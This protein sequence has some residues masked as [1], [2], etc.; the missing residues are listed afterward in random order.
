MVTGKDTEV[1]NPLSL[2]IT[3][4]A[5]AIKEQKD[6]EKERFGNIDAGLKRIANRLVINEGYQAHGN[7]E[8][9]ALKEMDSSEAVEIL[10]NRIIGKLRN[11]V[12]LIS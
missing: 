8:L 7:P 12:D 9:E 1:L 3:K 5:N 11:L 10:A 6:F 2:R 4:A